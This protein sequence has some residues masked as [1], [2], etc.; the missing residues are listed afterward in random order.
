VTNTRA[1]DA[2]VLK[3]AVESFIVQAMG[4]ENNIKYR[5]RERERERERER[6]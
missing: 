4:F 3:T 5:K 2:E 6:D 1:F